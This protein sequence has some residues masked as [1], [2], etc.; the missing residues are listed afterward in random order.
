LLENLQVLWG[1][2][3]ENR[4]ENV[5]IGKNLGGSEPYREVERVGPSH[6]GELPVRTG[7]TWEVCDRDDATHSLADVADA[8]PEKP[9]ALRDARS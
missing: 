2:A 5:Q 7:E 3:R 9:V 8:K 4:L 1:R 6:L